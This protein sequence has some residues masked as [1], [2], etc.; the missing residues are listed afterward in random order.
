MDEEYYGDGFFGKIAAFFKNMSGLDIL[1]AG[2]GILVVVVA[3]VTAMVYS[4]SQATKKKIAEFAPLGANMQTI[5]DLGSNQ[6]LA[7]ADARNSIPDEIIELE[8]VDE[9]PKEY[10]EKDDET[11]ISVTMSLTSVKKDLKIKFI[12]AK[13]KKLVAN[14]EFKVNIEDAKGKKYSATDDDMDGIIYLNS[15]TPGEA[16]VSMA[17]MPGEKGITYSKETAES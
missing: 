9:E 3:I 2:T 13:S 14:H 4:S 7:I 6:F 16:K 1:V 15:V 11:N 5:G 10:V 17:D 8:P 12:N